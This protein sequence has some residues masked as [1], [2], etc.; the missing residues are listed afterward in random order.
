MLKIITRRNQKMSSLHRYFTSSSKTSDSKGEHKQAK[1]EDPKK[2]SSARR[3]G[4]KKKEDEEDFVDMEVNA[5]PPAKEEVP[6][7]KPRSPSTKKRKRNVI[8]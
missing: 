7:I 6:Q 4:S 3:N 8:E 2:K 5:P 1:Q